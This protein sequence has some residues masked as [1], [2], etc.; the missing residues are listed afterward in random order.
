MKTV[1]FWTYYVR[2]GYLVCAFNAGYLITNVVKAVWDYAALA[3]ANVA[4]AS[5][6]LALG[7]Q[8]LRKN[9]RRVLRE[10]KGGRP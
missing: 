2:A 7:R 9:R 1:V 10:K 5:V 6:F 3:A 8:Q 4:C